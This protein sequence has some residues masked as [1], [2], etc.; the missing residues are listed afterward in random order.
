MKIL[1]LQIWNICVFFLS[2]ITFIRKK[3]KGVI[4]G[5]NKILQKGRNIW[6][7]GYL[8]VMQKKNYAVGY[9][10]GNNAILNC[11]GCVPQ[12]INLKQEMPMYYY[13]VEIRVED[14]NIEEEG[15]H[16][17]HQCSD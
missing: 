2:A 15:W 1:S 11:R 13:D 8:V 9:N 14:E 4:F 16:C 6:F 5:G 7:H 17:H 10:I 3:K 12:E